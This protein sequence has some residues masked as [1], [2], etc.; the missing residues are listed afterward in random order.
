MSYGPFDWTGGP[1]L[2]LYCG[3]LLL[4][5]YAG[6]AIPARLRPRGSGIPITDPDE[7]AYLAGGTRRFADSI[8]ARLFAA[9]AITLTTGGLFTTDPSHPARSDAER[10]V[11][12]VHGPAKWRTVT[13]AIEP[14]AWPVRQRLIRGGKLM[15]E[16]SVLAMR[17]WQTLPYLL[18]IVF[19]AIKWEIGTQRERPVG[20]LTAL[21]I[22]TAIL[23]LIRF[24]MVDRR[25]RA[26]QAAMDEARSRFDRMRRA[27]TRDEIGLAVA[28]FGTSVL[29]ATIWGDYHRARND[30]SSSSSGD[31]GSHGGGGDSGGGGGCGGGCGG[32]GS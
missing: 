22:L 15:T 1:F 5:I 19:G 26:G 9:N 8:I 10:S 6:F 25:T 23:A 21:L 7:F 12:E 31:G 27:P 14:H 28:L 24:C 32:C 20:Y 3:L 30:S 4:T 13:A 2:T 29:L 18:L 17:V 16:R 11:L